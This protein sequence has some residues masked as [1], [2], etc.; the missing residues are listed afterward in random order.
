[1]VLQI[2]PDGPGH[3]Y[4]T[5]DVYLE[6]P[7]PNEAEWEAVRFLDEVLQVED[8]AIVE[9]IQRGMATPGFDHGRIVVEEGRTGRSEHAVHHFHGLL[10]EAY[11]R[12][13]TATGGGG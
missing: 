2:L 4:E 1:M 8:I 9:S 5:L 6:S 7:E 10:L 13:L 12:A 11:G 3:T